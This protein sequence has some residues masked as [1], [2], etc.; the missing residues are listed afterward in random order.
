MNISLPLTHSQ[1]ALCETFSTAQMCHSLRDYFSMFNPTCHATF[2]LFIVF[3]NKII[4][5]WIRNVVTAWNSPADW[6][7]T[8]S[9][10]IIENKA[11]RKMALL[12]PWVI[13]AERAVQVKNHT[14]MQYKFYSSLKLKYGI[15]K[16]SF[17]SYMGPNHYINNRERESNISLLRLVPLDN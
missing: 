12:R 2:T 1:Y 5:H 16:L 7:E 3:N 10:I 17:V 15:F 4:F 6:W 11:S 9:L 8:K 13:T 14:F